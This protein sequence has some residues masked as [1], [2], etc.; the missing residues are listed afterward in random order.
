MNREAM[1]KQMEDVREELNRVDE[2]KVALETILKGYEAWFRTNPENGYKSSRQL[3]LAV[4]GRGGGAKGTISFRKGVIEVLHQ[5]RGAAL[6]EEE[7]WH[8]MKQM[9]VKSDAKRPSGFVGMTAS[10]LEEAEK[11]AVRTWRWKGPLSIGVPSITMNPTS[12]ESH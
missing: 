3:E 10:G 8:R 1:R 7:I 6:H 4:P 5:A 12:G 9:G 2:Q 11:V